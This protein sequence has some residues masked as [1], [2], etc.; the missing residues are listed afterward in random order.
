MV[1]SE[2]AHQQQI[3]QQIDLA[4]DCLRACHERG[5]QPRG[6]SEVTV[7]KTTRTQSGARSG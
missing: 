2:P 6:I 1:P 3:V 4:H 5:R 7:W